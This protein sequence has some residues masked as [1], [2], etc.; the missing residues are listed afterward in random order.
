MQGLEETG[1]KVMYSIAVHD[2]STY[3]I[4]VREKSMSL[5]NTTTAM[6]AFWDQF[7][8]C[9]TLNLNFLPP[10][11]ASCKKGNI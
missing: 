9:S 10:I 3:S 4:H 5:S 8:I 1:A 2:D 11:N 7:S 6:H